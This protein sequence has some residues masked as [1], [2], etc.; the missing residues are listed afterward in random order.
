[1]TSSVYPIEGFPTVCP[2]RDHKEITIRPMI[3][4]DE[5]ALVE[6]FRR[7]PEAERLYLKEDV[8]DPMH[9]IRA[10]SLV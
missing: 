3:A 5:H 7:V 2:I 4:A 8:A 6:F 10:I 9:Q 1:M